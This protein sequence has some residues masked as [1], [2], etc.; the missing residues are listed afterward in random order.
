MISI[1]KLQIKFPS[2]SLGPVSLE[3]DSHSFFA[4]MGPTG[5][6]KTL[7]LESIAGLLKS[8]WGS[9][10][11]DGQ[12][13]TQ[14]PPEQRNV[15]LVYQDN[16]LFPH[17]TCFENII[18]G[19]RYNNIEE[20]EGKRY[21]LEL[22]EMLSI[23]QLQVR[24]PARLSGGEKQRVALA[25]ALACRPKVV[26]LDEPLS[27]LDPQFREGLRKNLKQLHKSSGAIFF[28]VTHDFVDAL[29]LADK[30]AVIHKG[31]I[32]QSGQTLDIFHRPS[33]TFIAD[34]VGM[35]NIFEA[36]Y[37]NGLCT[38]KGI[39]I[40]APVSVG[41]KQKGHVA[42]R[43]EDIHIG[44]E[45]EFSSGEKRLSG[46]VTG[47]IRDGFTWIVTLSCCDAVFT[48][49]LEHRLALNGTIQEGTELLFGFRHDVVHHISDVPC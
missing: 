26:L 44:S 12:D 14:A 30:A 3:V 17:L 27:S 4:L 24:K 7:L 46:S 1:D 34:F 23:D 31:H 15:G 42:L 33:T 40:P 28:M 43:P 36:S 19:Q 16:S 9:I 25:R 2:F 18:Y 37:E 38:F 21:A 48:A 39:T 35:K 29:T 11:I 41:S 32:E 47:L 6:G 5:S 49:R 10:C 22:M 8:D 45:G 20:T 13:I